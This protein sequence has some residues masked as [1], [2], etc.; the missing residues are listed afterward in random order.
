M[1]LL[2]LPPDSRR[3]FGATHKAIFD[4]ADVA[5]LG[6]SAT[7]NFQLAPVSGNLPVGTLVQV[8]GTR[9][10]TGFDFSDAG[11]TSLAV[12]IGDAGNNAR[13]LASQE[14]AID[15]TLVTYK[16]G[17][18]APGFVITTAGPVNAYFT[19]A[20]GGTPTLVEC[21]SGKAEVYFN[22]VDL[23]PLSR[24]VAS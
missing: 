24:V 12:T 8:I 5:A 6:A 3:E 7:G 4:F 1:K 23:S 13:Y 19:A 17:A 18:L 11:I 22:I 14:M 9:V 21:T 20:N 10:I 2:P 15:G 16:A